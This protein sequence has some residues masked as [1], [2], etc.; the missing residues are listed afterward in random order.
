MEG[1]SII[2]KG[3]KGGNE[4][5][6]VSLLQATKSSILQDFDQ[7][8]RAKVKM[9]T[10]NALF[11]TAMTIHVTIILDICR[12]IALV[13]SLCILWQEKT[14]P[15]LLT[16]HR[17]LFLCCFTFVDHHRFSTLHSFRECPLGSFFRQMYQIHPLICT[18]TY[19]KG[20]NPADML[21]PWVENTQI[22]PRTPRLTTPHQR[23]HG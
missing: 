9:K 3:Q 21:R 13:S 18:S 15:S 20:E 7:T 1:R 17:F 6:T 14:Y 10:L 8:K 5:E 2:G 11:L 23:C 19:S 22:P 4:E 12:H 16:E